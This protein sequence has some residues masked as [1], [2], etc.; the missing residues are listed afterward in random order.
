MEGGEGNGNPLQ[1]SYLENPRDRGAWWSAIYGVGKSQT[2]LKQLSSRS[3]R[4]QGQA[5]WCGKWKCIQAHVFIHPVS[6][7]LLVGAFNPFAFKVM[8]DIYDP[9]TIFVIVLGL[10]SVGLF[11]LLHFLPREVPLAFVVKLIWWCWIL[12]IF[13]YLEPFDFSIKS[14]GQTC[15]VE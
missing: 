14:E 1:Y 5:E 2:Q 9:I 6:L 10:F 8:I 13:A 11:L 7:C 4:E 3:S 12:L 15:W